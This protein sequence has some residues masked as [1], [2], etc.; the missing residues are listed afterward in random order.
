MRRKW[1]APKFFAK[2]FGYWSIVMI[3]FILIELMENGN[4]PK[5]HAFFTGPNAWIAFIPAIVL[6]IL[7]WLAKSRKIL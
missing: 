7:R 2:V 4:L 6:T 5:M 1:D 3:P